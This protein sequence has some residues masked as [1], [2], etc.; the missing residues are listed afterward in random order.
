[1]KLSPMLAR[2][3]QGQPPE[4]WL[5]SEKLDGVRA[6]WDGARLWSRNGMAFAAPE[7]FTAQLPAGVVLDGELFMGRG[8]FQAAVGAVRKKV[9]V[10]GEWSRLRF[11]VFDAPEI[12]GGFEERLAAAAAALGECAVASV[13]PHRVCQGQEDLDGFF[14]EVCSAGGEGV[15]LRAADRRLAVDLGAD[16]AINEAN[17]TGAMLDKPPLLVPGT[18]G[19]R[20]LGPPLPPWVQVMLKMIRQR[21]MMCSAE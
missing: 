6:V 21:F 20:L 13:V 5:V 7:W 14:A 16:M 9:P 10:D 12:E 15:M 8:R 18:A 19:Q 2:A 3:Y 11:C 1:M 4:G 17:L